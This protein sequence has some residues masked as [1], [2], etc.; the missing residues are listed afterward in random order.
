[1]TGTCERL[2]NH[3]VIYIRT[4]VLFFGLDT[5]RILLGFI[6][7]TMVGKLA[8]KPFSLMFEDFTAKTG[9]SL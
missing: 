5:L 4:E 9:F 3:F 1:M 6:N 7:S 2:A 8:S